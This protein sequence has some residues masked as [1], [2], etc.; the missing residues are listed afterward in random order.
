MSKYIDSG[1]VGDSH[2]PYWKCL[3]LGASTALYRLFLKRCTL[4]NKTMGLYDWPWPCPYLLRGD[5]S[6][7][8]FLFDCFLGLLQRLDLS[9]LTCSLGGGVCWGGYYRYFNILFY[10]PF[11]LVGCWS[12]VSIRRVIYKFQMSVLFIARVLME[13]GRLAS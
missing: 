8:F 10:N 2:C 4:T 9:S 13:V 3:K 12:L 6:L 11:S 5:R 1:M 7:T